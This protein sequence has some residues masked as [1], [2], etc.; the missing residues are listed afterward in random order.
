MPISASV[1]GSG[2]DP[3]TRVAEYVAVANSHPEKLADVVKEVVRTGVIVP[4]PPPLANVFIG[5]AVDE[6]ETSWWLKMS[7]TIP[8]LAS[9]PEVHSFPNESKMP[10]ESKST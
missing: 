2:A 10:A 1:A 6:N 7:T 9:A 8:I 4:Q 5:T 3:G